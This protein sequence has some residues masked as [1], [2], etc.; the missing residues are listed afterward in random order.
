MNGYVEKAVACK[1]IPITRYK[2][3][4]LIKKGTVRFIETLKLPSRRKT[5]YVKLS[6]I[7]E[8]LSGIELEYI[9]VKNIP[10]QYGMTKNAVRYQIMHGRLRW[11]RYG[12][13]LHVCKSDFELFQS[14]K[15]KIPPKR[16]EPLHCSVFV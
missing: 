1:R 9:E 6:D 14:E 11:I 15:S 13:S 5:V 12:T 10:H 4:S 3:D 8:Y 16:L 7:E 2:L